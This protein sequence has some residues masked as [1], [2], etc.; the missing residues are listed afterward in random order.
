MRADLHV[1]SSASDGQLDPARLLLAARRGG[2]DLLAI[3]DHDTTDGVNAVRHNT[4]EGLKLLPAIELSTV[5]DGW[6]LHFL[7]YGVDPAHPLMIRYTAA[8]RERRKQR[9]RRMVGLLQAMN[10]PISYDD[11]VATAGSRVSSIGRAHLARSLQLA[12]HVESTTEAFQRFLGS[13]K[14]AYVPSD[15]LGPREAFDLI[16]ESAGVAVWAHP[17]AAIFEKQLQR[18]SD[19]GLDGVECLRP[20]LAPAE[21]RFL[22]QGARRLG[23]LI[24]GGSDWHGPEHGPLGRFALGR[25]P[26]EALLDRCGL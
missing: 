19:W 14:P 18:F 12:G 16:H 7:G 8:A 1:H 21:T 17:P 24:S 10:I 5:H 15:L 4:P 13:G 22:Q 2:L 20:Y 11:V 23:L 6:D 3:T 26:I 9:M 25:R